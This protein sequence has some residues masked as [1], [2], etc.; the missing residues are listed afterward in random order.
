[1]RTLTTVILLMVL[2]ASCGDTKRPEGVIPPAKMEL[3]L[4]DVLLAE[5]FSESYLTVDTTKKLPEWYGQELDKVLALHQVSQ[6]DFLA[7]IDYYKTQP[8]EFK[9]IMDTVNARALRT[10]D[11]V[12]KQV[13]EKKSK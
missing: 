11:Q 13:M 6:K 8:E 10:K 7:S 5:S 9:V 2:L 1:M 12:F 3:V 4:M